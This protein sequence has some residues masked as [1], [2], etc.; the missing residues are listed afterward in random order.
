MIRVLKRVPSSIARK[1]VSKGQAAPPTLSKRGQKKADVAASFAKAA[2][3]NNDNENAWL[4]AFPASK[5]LHKPKSA[6]SAQVYLRSP[7]FVLIQFRG[8]GVKFPDLGTCTL[9]F[10]SP[11]LEH[12]FCHERGP[13]PTRIHRWVL[14]TIFFVVYVVYI[15][16]MG[17]KQKSAAVWYE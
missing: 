5:K 1:V 8:V 13:V 11:A 12:D 14:R 17:T 3:V 10:L 15:S 4:D 2:G 7:A 6:I 16:I 9:E